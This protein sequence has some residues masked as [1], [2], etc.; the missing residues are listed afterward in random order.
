MASQ[1]P[2]VSGLPVGQRA[3]KIIDWI[4]AYSRLVDLES[5]YLELSINEPDKIKAKRYRLRSEQYVEGI[6]NFIKKLP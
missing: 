3:K 6:N 1:N 4:G 2:P 5:K